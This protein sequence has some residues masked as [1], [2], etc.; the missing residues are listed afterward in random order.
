MGNECFNW[1]NSDK[2]ISVNNKKTSE[3]NEISEFKT[4]SNFEPYRNNIKYNINIPSNNISNCIDN[5]NSSRVLNIDMIISNNSNQHQLQPTLGKRS[6]SLKIIDKERQKRIQKFTRDELEDEINDI[7][8][9]R[10]PFFEND[11]LKTLSAFTFLSGN[12]PYHEGLMFFTTNKNFYIAQSY[13]ITFI[14]VYDFYAGISEIISFNNINSNSKK[15]NIPEIY[16]PQQRITLFNVLNIINNM[17]NR[18]NLINENC[19]N[20]CNTILESLQSKYRIEL[21]DKPSN[22]K[23]NFLKKQQ[24]K[25]KGYNIPYNKIPMYG[26]GRLN[27]KIHKI[28]I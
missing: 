11:I 22:E 8:R 5:P 21:D 9:I 16:M 26:S 6:N 14:K 27:K 12:G 20:F 10:I 19:Q 28:K 13:P 1:I 24:K 17:P 25:M 23:I 18:Y 4:I 15:Y 2:D 3:E 7:L